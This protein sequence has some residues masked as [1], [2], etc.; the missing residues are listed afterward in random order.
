MELDVKASLSVF[1]DIKKRGFKEEDIK[2]KSTLYEI[3]PLEIKTFFS[4]VRNEPE[5]IY[6]FLYDDLST[7]D[8]LTLLEV[9]QFL[10]NLRH[11]LIT[12]TLDKY[13]TERDF[14]VETEVD[15]K[16]RFSIDS[17]KRLDLFAVNMKRKQIYVIECTRSKDASILSTK[18]TKYNDIL[19]KIEEMYKI[20]QI[21]RAVQQ[22]CR[23]RSRM[24]S[25][26]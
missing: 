15:V 11:D 19:K 17:K 21:G 4:S 5:E 14:H 25:S 16:G 8:F 26:A 13:F 22:E 3:E 24:P 6:E 12:V 23:D 20:V 9:A 10:Y 7:K 2:L 1:S 18:A